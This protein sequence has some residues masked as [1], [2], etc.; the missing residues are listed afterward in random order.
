MGKRADT[1]ADYASDEAIVRKLERVLRGELRGLDPRWVGQEFSPLGPRRHIAA[2]RR[3]IADAEALGKAPGEVGAAVV[4]R[5]YLLTQESLAEELG[6]LQAL[7]PPKKRDVANDAADAEET[8]Y[9]AFMA[10][11]SNRTRGQQ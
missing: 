6:K 1:L 7:K 2:V 10:R 9:A 4:A 3:R 11:A 5:R 8:A